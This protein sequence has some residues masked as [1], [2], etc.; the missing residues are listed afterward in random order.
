MH[1]YQLVS[2]LDE[3]DAEDWAPVSRPQV[4]YSLTKLKEMNLISISKKSVP[5]LGPEKA[6]YQI[7]SRGRVALKEALTEDRWSVQR[8]VPPFM[9]WMA[10]SSQLSKSETQKMID[11]RRNFLLAQLEKEQNTLEEFKSVKGD[12]VT[13]AKLM[14]NF[15]VKQFE[16]E[17]TWLSD[18]E[19]T[20]SK[21]RR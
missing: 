7:L 14:V 17:L 16:A 4:Y 1:G 12:M 5:A 8:T 18:V 9:T 11:K 2:T 6:T 13:A 21:A 19:E 10:L 3:R 20:L 15:S